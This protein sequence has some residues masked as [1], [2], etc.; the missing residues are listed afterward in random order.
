MKMKKLHILYKA[1]LIFL[2]FQ[3]TS[4]GI[5]LGQGSGPS[6]V[7][8][9]QTS[10]YTYDDG[11]LKIT[12]TWFLFGNGTIQSTDISGTTYTCTILWQS[13]GTTTVSFRA[14]PD[15]SYPKPLEIWSKSVSVYAALTGGSISGGGSTY[16]NGASVT[17]SNSSTATGGNG[18]YNYRWEWYKNGAW[19]DAIP[20][21]TGTSYT[22]NPTESLQYRRMVWSG[23]QIAYSNTIQVNVY[24][25]L[26]AGSISGTQSI[27]IGQTASTLTNSGT[28]S[29]GH[30]T[31]AYVWQQSSNGSSWSN[32]EGNSNALTYAPGAI[33]STKW[34]KR[35][36]KNSC[37]ASF[38]FTSSVKVTVNSL[39]SAPTSVSV[40]TNTCGTKTL[41]KSN[42]SWYWQGTNSSGTSTNSTASN[43]TYSVTSE[44]TYYV[45][46]KDS[47]GCWSSPL[48][49]FVEYNAIPVPPSNLSST[50]NTCGDKTITM[51]SVPTNTIG[52]WQTS[53][54]GD[55]TTHPT[56]WIVN[57][58][59]DYFA[60]SLSSAG[61]WSIHPIAL[62]VVVNHD[63]E[64]F[65][66][67]YSGDVCDNP[68]QI[69]AD[70]Y[71]S[72]SESGVD[73]QLKKDGVEYRASV[74]GTGGTL[75][76]FNVWDEGVFT[77]TAST[78]TCS[79]EMTG[80]PTFVIHQLP[81][82]NAGADMT[83]FKQNSIQLTGSPSGGTWS[84]SYVS[85]STF[86]AAQAVTGSYNLGYNYIDPTTGC[87]NLDKR[88]V[89]VIDLPPFQA[90]GETRIS[91][92]DNVS[93]STN[94]GFQ[95]Y[96][97]YKDD[98]AISGATS[99][100]YAASEEGT[101]TLDVSTANDTYRTSGIFVEVINAS[102]DQNYVITKAYQVGTVDAGQVPDTEVIQQTA[103]FDGLGRPMQTVQIGQSP[104]GNDLVQPIA[105]DEFG[106]E[107]MQYLPYAAN[108]ATGIFKTSAIS[109]QLSFYQNKPDVVVDPSPYSEKVFELSPLN[110]VLEQ[111]APGAAWQPVPDDPNTP[112]DETLNGRTV[113]FAYEVNI[114]EDAVYQWQISSQDK[115][116]SLG[117]T[118]YYVAGELYKNVTI[119]E[120]GHL[121]IEFTDKLK[122][123]VL[124]R[125]QAVESPNL[126]TYVVG[127]WADTYYVYDDFRNLR[128]VLPPEAI[129][130][131]E[132]DYLSN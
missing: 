26:N 105:Y 92:G 71:L 125:V 94:S 130:N 41:T 22:F 35:G 25:P 120:Q 9:G 28:P 23:F 54:T 19:S 88:T 106:R 39:P 68:Q 40:S 124:K 78:A 32:V 29:G 89:T 97:W 66:L 33:T 30:G 60:R 115:W 21:G 73:Y 116:P 75:E 65:D 113:R 44:G 109:D 53:S 48:G 70:F 72:G 107:A 81:T 36:F 43:S 112:E 86:S 15:F 96:Q 50:Q 4:I 95:S 47:N 24:N 34:Y 93:L 99:N 128:Y 58:S 83:V 127:E 87:S 5:V 64:I 82:V 20:S 131:V 57:Q 102:L 56:T 77:V 37:S 45:R 123:T 10:V 51:G 126:S 117:G 67:T 129:K 69:G 11:E 101:Y 49:V 17:L 62:P 52:Y 59:G 61:C 108:E 74:P 103:Y 91:I 121:V 98:V 122:Q 76:W 100:M 111:G 114:T 85:G 27:C 119:D 8:V 1:G 104:E 118:G 80:T 7:A 110:R 6:E 18:S 79:S 38:V 132:T 46:A 2:A 16:C 55:S 13:S 42:N 63:P 12:P 90:N 14:K 3:S 31:P 84:G